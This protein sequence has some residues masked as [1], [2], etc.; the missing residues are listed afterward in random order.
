MSSENS[1][2][3]TQNQTVLHCFENQDQERETR[4]RQLANV[5]IDM[6]IASNTELDSA[7]LLVN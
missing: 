1:E 5:F 4:L 6:F 7:V 2:I 3:Q